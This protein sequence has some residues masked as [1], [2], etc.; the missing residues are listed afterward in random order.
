MYLF[1]DSVGLFE[2]AYQEFSVSHHI[3]G[4]AATEDTERIYI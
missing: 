1:F 3:A 2:C 4:E